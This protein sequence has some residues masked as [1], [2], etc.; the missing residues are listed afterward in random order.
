MDLAGQPEAQVTEGSVPARCGDWRRQPVPARY[1][2][3]VEAKRAAHYWRSMHGRARRRIA[4][5]QARYRESQRELADTRERKERLEERVRELEQD[6]AGLR[7]RNRDLLKAP[8]GKRSEKRRGAGEGHGE[9]ARTDRGG[10]R[11]RR[12]GGQRGARAHPRLEQTGLEVRDEL[13]E[14]EAGSCRCRDCGRPFR[15]HGEEVS[16]RLEVRVRGYVRRIR[17]PRY[18]A[19]C[20]CA[21]RQGQRVPEAIAPP[22]PALFR[23]SHY[24]L[25]VWVAYLV[26]VHWQRQPARAFER[27]WAECGVRLAASTLL[28]HT[29]DLLT[30]FEPLEQ[31][32]GARQRQARVVHGDE[33]SWPVHE[34]AE[35]GRNARCWLWV[36]LSRDAARF[37]VDPSRSAEAAA[38]LFG[39][40]GQERPA[41]LVCDRYSAYVR[42]A[43]QRRGQ[44]ELA[45]CFAHVRRDFV[46]LGRRRP[47]LQEWADGIV[48][49]IGALYA[50][51]AERLRL[52]D[53]QAGTEGRSEAFGASQRRL[54]AACAALFEQA[55]KDRRALAAAQEERGEP[56]PRL[57]PLRSL[58]KH[59]AGLEVFLAN[60]I[61][62]MDNNVAE[63]ALRRPVVGRKLS[64]G[65]HSERGAALQ[66]VLLSVFVT[67]D[68]AGI[69]LRR[70]LEAFLGECAAI[71]PRAAVAD[72]RAWLPWGMPGERLERLRAPARRRPGQ[73]PAP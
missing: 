67:L 39:Q 28:G 29:R 25:S 62:P 56:D 23:G 66:G 20:E 55:A 31:A 26:Q 41:V 47:Q 48:D 70:W 35:A 45:I 15:R 17:R 73:G 52:W 54:E 12:R 30:W 49:R 24:G 72:P 69:D 61:V 11:K 68:M 71:G 22:P 13:R 36:C 40:I 21:S 42:L 43:R 53:A 34:R 18:R 65:S 50:L 19:A 3:L 8:F 64:H 59:R 2:A 51:N 46:A 58:L 63:R 32:I 7:Q 57:G 16:E 9:T 37:R 5:W 1:G 14:P 10:G 44:F 4:E 6:N 38:Q 60:P 27:Q 33:T